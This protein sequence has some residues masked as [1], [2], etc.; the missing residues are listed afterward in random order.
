MW[1]CP[2][3][4]YF[5]NG[6]LAR[7][8]MIDHWSFRI[9]FLQTNHI[10]FV[11]FKFHTNL[12]GRTMMYN[13]TSP[14]SSQW[15]SKKPRIATAF[16]L[17]RWL[18]SKQVWFHPDPI[19]K[20]LWIYVIRYY[21]HCMMAIYIYIMAEPIMNPSPIVSDM[22]SINHPKSSKI[23]PNSSFIVRFTIFSTLQFLCCHPLARHLQGSPL[24]VPQTH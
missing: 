5:S 1:F 6:Y 3:V 23:I 22:G 21:L 7:T 2:K 11:G 24:A 12:Y 19:W 14:K 18:G 4:G 13:G 17:R 15:R 16:L 10:S 9:P 20:T 8:I